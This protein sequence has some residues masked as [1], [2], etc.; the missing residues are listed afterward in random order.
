MRDIVKSDQSKQKSVVLTPSLHFQIIRD[1][2][3]K[4]S[5]S[6]RAETT[7][8]KINESDPG[9][10]D[11]RPVEMLFQWKDGYIVEG[12]RF[13]SVTVWDAFAVVASILLMLDRAYTTWGRVVNKVVKTKSEMHKQRYSP[14]SA[15]YKLLKTIEE[16]CT[17]L[18]TSL[19]AL[20]KMRR[21][22]IRLKRLDHKRKLEEERIKVQVEA[23][24]NKI[25]KKLAVR[26]GRVSQD[27]LNYNEK[28]ILEWKAYRKMLRVAIADEELNRKEM[29]KR[30][31]ERLRRLEE[32]LMGMETPDFIEPKKQEK[33]QSIQSTISNDE[34]DA[35]SDIEWSDNEGEK[36]KAV[37]MK[38]AEFQQEL[39]KK[40]KKFINIQFNMPGA[41]IDDAQMIGAHIGMKGDQLDTGPWLMNQPAKKSATNAPKPAQW[42]STAFES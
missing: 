40:R 30:D 32:A 23:I 21:V 10:F 22:E 2:G 6:I 4:Q 34:S 19:V 18:F 28:R 9:T 42:M 33:R 12:D 17:N 25:R 26:N 11:Y 3:I 24:V 27:L 35:S 5:S 29:S 31:A 13:I 8:S 41:Q 15:E 36:E 38:H 39:R 1:E 16:R 37:V 20:S 7:I 14:D